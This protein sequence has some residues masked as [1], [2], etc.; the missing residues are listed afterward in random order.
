ME[1]QQNSGYIGRVDNEPSP[2]EYKYE[3]EAES[4]YSETSS[5]GS[6]SSDSDTRSRHHH[7]RKTEEADAP[8]FTNTLLYF[9]SLALIALS[10]GYFYWMSIACA[11]E[12]NEETNL[13][14]QYALDQ[15]IAQ[16]KEKPQ[17]DT[18]TKQ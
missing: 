11:V 1:I 5:H 17:D 7:T 3:H 18:I 6:R 9:C 15:I 12:E 2:D 4:V 10:I 14:I 13:T 8:F 16:P